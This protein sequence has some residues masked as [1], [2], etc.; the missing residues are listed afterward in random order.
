MALGGLSPALDVLSTCVIA[1]DQRGVARPQ[2]SGG[3]CDIGSYEL[4][5]TAPT[6]TINQAAGQADPTNASPINFT[7]VFSEP[8]TGF[9]AGD[10]SFTGSTVGGTL[11]ATVTGGPTT[12]NVAV[13]GMTT[14]GDVVASVPAA[15]ATDL[16][17]NNNTASTSTDN[18]V[19]F[20]ATAPTVTINQAAGQADPTNASPINFTVVFSEPVTGFATGDVTLSGTAGATTATVTGGPTTY[21]VAVTGMTVG[22]TVIAS[23]P[24][25]VATDALGNNNVASSSTDNTVLYDV[26]YPIVSSSVPANNATVSPG[27]I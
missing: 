15:A 5:A 8:V 26:G 17:G 2:P 21:N 9:A 7:V 18:T 16:A 22:G 14:P 19:T 10:V 23:V 24:A 3:N 1:S 12:Y 20:D 27:P 13:T 11:V 6:V 4:D 25:G